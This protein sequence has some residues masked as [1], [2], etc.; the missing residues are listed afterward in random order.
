M[1]EG[2]KSKSWCKWSEGSVQQAMVSCMGKRETTSGHVGWLG[3]HGRGAKGREPGEW[4]RQA[5]FKRK[6]ASGWPSG[7]VGGSCE[8]KGWLAKLARPS[9]VCR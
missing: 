3:M 2:T 8:V 4:V 7:H 6:V 5:T 9:R 1:G